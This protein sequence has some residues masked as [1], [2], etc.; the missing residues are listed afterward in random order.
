MRVLRRG[1]FFLPMHAPEPG[2]PLTEL[3]P[4]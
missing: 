2:I 4:G 3:F 1:E